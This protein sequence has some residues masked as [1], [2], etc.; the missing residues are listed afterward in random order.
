[1]VYDPN[2]PQ[3]SGFTGSGKWFCSVPNTPL[4]HITEEKLLQEF[5]GGQRTD[6]NAEFRAWQILVYNQTPGETDYFGDFLEMV[7]FGCV[8]FNAA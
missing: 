1:M 5:A 6:L 4:A 8:H 3:A 2:H 7:G